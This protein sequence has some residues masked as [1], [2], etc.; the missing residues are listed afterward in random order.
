MSTLELIQVDGVIK[1]V[2]DVDDTT[3]RPAQWGV[4]VY[5]SMEPTF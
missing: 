5:V 4:Y 1:Y 2:G 3:G